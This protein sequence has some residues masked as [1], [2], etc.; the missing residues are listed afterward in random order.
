MCGIFGFAIADKNVTPAQRHIL[1]ALLAVEMDERGGDS[2]GVT[3]GA[4][5]ERGIG[6]LASA[7]TARELGASK[8][9]CAHTRKATVGG[10]TV[11]NAHPFTVGRLT[12]AHNGCLNNHEAMNEKHNRTCSVD[13]QHIFH[14]LNEKKNLKDI[15][16]W[17]SVWYV[18]H[19]TPEYIYLFRSNSTALHVYGVGKYP[20]EGRGVIF[21]ST[22]H[23]VETAARMAGIPVFPYEIKEHMLYSV[24]GGRVWREGK[25][26]RLSTAYTSV[27]TRPT[28]DAEGWGADEYGEGAL[29]VGFT[30]A[31]SPYLY[32]RQRALGFS[33]DAPAV[34]VDMPAVSVCNSCY[35][36]VDGAEGLIRVG[37]HDVCEK[38]A[39]NL[40]REI[41]GG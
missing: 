29:G 15:S 8:M 30:S 4:D 39:P 28:W 36:L 34:D 10:I 38:C 26:C 1:G 11:D 13:S 12:G 6:T 31:P 19:A 25:S 2:W 33:V 32:P 35:E 16:G 22:A 9:L 5:A 17:A 20:K 41:G 37:L 18:E 21:A 23:A 3:R 27:A 24:K 40:R 14:H 7:L